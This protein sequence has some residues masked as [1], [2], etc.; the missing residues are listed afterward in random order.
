[1][2][3][4]LRPPQN[5]GPRPRPISRLGHN[6]PRPRFSK[7]APQFLPLHQRL[8]GSQVT[9]RRTGD[10]CRIMSPRELALRVTRQ[11]LPCRR[12]HHDLHRRRK[13]RYLLLPRTLRFNIPLL[14]TLRSIKGL[15]QRAFP[16]ARN[17]PSRPW[18][19]GTW[20]TSHTPN[21]T[22]PLRQ[23]GNNRRLPCNPSQNQNHHRLPT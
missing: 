14:L 22:A 8:V 17:S 16:R 19:P 6:P 13:A 11:L 7:Q 3:D 4:R 2:R 23:H 1:M 18:I 21:S 20:R 10:Q 9:M 5:R 12:K 15:H